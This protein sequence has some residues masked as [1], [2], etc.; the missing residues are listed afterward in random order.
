[1]DS[2]ET[3]DAIWNTIAAEERQREQ[4]KATLTPQVAQ[5]AGVLHN[6]YPFL[7]G[8]VKLSAA[9][10]GLTD[11]QVLGIA[12]SAARVKPQID[13]NKKSKKNWLQR[14]I[15][16]KLKTGSRYGFAALQL[17]TDLIQGAASQAF[18]DKPG[19]SG[20]FISTDLGSLIANDTEA[21]TGF[22]MGGRA[23]ELQAE[24]ARRFRGTIDGSAWTIGRGL[25]SVAFEPDSAAY[26]LMSGAFDAGIAIAT[27][28]VPGARQAGAAL[29]AAEEAGKGGKVVE[30]LAGATRIVGEGSREIGITRLTA[31][32]IDD[33]RKGIL[34]GNQV[35]Y[36][37]A[38]RFFG[39]ALGRRIVQRT[40]ETNDFA[41]TW[42]LW[43]RK[44]DA[45]T[46]QELAD[47]KTESEVM[48]VLLDKLGTQVVST[49]ELAGTKK[50]YLSL[51]QRNKML[52]AMP[53]GEGVSRAFSKLPQRSFNLS[54]AETAAD[55]V[56][57][58]NTIE[59]TMALFKV[60]PTVRAGYLNRAGR[61]LIDR[62]PSEV[63][64]FYDDFEVLLKDSMIA[65]GTN[66]NIVEQIYSNFKEYRQD[67]PVFSSDGLGS[68]DDLEIAQRLFADK[69]NAADLV[70]IG[71]LAAS[72]IAK[73]EF[74]IPDIRQVRRLTNNW[75][76][77]W[78]KK[79]PN[80]AKLAE[81][82]ELRLPFAVVE[83]FQEKIWRPVITLTVGNFVR[84]VVD[85]QVSIALSGKKGGVSPFVHP[86]QYLGLVRNRR[87]M[88][89]IMAQGFDEPV[90][91]RMVEDALVAHRKAVYDLMSSQYQ[92]PVAMHRKAVRMGVFMPYQRI[93]GQISADVARA[94]GDEL[95]RIS[96]DWAT[97]MYA[98]GRG[99]DEIIDIIRNGKESRFLANLDEAGR[100]SMADQAQ[101]WYRDINT[102]Y[103]NG[104]PI[105]N[106]A[107]NTVE[108]M[109]VNLDDA[110]NLKIV[111]E[112]AS[113]RL[114][115][116]T[117][118]DPR[119]KD[120]VGSGKMPT[121]V[122]KA[123]DIVGEVSDGARVKV[124][125]FNKATKTYD[126]YEATV[127]AYGGR[128]PEVE[129]QPFAWSGTGDTS[130][131]FEKFLQAEDIYNNPNMPVR[132]V[133]EVRNPNTPQ[134]A[135]LKR[136][137][138]R[139]IRKF[140]ASLYEQPVGTLERSP[141]FKNLYYQWVDK[142]AVSMDETS[143]NNIIDE[144]VAKAGPENPERYLPAGLWKKL[145]DL[146]DNPDKLYGTLSREE[147]NAF[148]SGHAID[149]MERMLYNA[150][151]RSNATDVLRLISPFAQQQLEFFGRLGRMGFSP[152]AGGRLGALPNPESFRKMQLVVEG[153]RDADPD[154][155]GKGFFF[156]DPTTGQWSFTFPLTGELTKLITGVRADLTLPIKGV[157]LGLDVRPGLGPFATIAASKIL[158][159][160]P[161]F[162]FMRNI[163]LPYGEKT[164]VVRSLVPSYVQKI[165]DG[166]SGRE[167]GRFFANTY[168]ETMQALSAT[169]K[170]DLSNPDEQE[171]MMNDARRKAQILV[172]LRGITQFTGP[173]SGDFDTTVPTD[174][175][176][177]HATGLAYA[178]Q[179]LRNDNYD[180]ATLRFIEIFGEDAF[181]YLSNKTIS[182]VGGLEASEEF[183]KWERNNPSLFKQFKDVAGYFGPT[184]T[185]F[186][187]EAYTRQLQ[188]GARR[189]LTPQEVL[190]AS[191]R[192]IGLAYYKDMRAKFGDSL[193]ENERQYLSDYRALIEQ[194]YPGFANMKFDPNEVSNK[195]DLL[196]QASAQE[197][198][199]GNQ[200]AEGLRF[201]QR[202]RELALAEAQ[203]RGFKSLG[204]TKLA[205]LHAYLNSYAESIIAKYPDFARVYNRVLSQEFE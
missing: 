101:A 133:G 141:I 38:N 17:P 72:E 80:I 70:N 190:D 94:H 143:I 61:I 202:V 2:P 14:N 46:T 16:D 173:A 146:K 33:I 85:S 165:A 23:R 87:L 153:G 74:H 22:F 18:D 8:G 198:L 121:V 98:T 83:S 73:R 145:N 71:P 76:W 183:S 48:N 102:R 103:K 120:I 69:D 108:W 15:V 140:H 175:G 52:K 27:P 124:R 113:R 89:D 193:K 167:G 171:R 55:Q 81:A 44:L 109:P 126:E 45:K 199:N 86:F 78:V 42:A 106:K 104:Q 96:A 60:D 129:V 21:G 50:T 192:A 64:K 139:M 191:Q 147:V 13:E 66:K 128:G 91:A 24:R 179:N 182:N 162:D 39:T 88:S 40:A 67:M 26:R 43:G 68:A 116:L 170:Y 131:N 149:Q 163:L 25:A 95:G 31:D 1:M 138:D 118:G 201:Y 203:N 125:S 177:I 134:A 135:T 169:G 204:S 151:E 157:A 11:E 56:G 49:R 185:E 4:L 29:R 123:D 158:P 186:D 111:L 112:G 154:G 127:V 41:E 159:D 148:A 197:D 114:D 20:F 156:K 194:K 35:D 180:T 195:I 110:D 62:N 136:S 36:Q 51:A 166:L 58:L 84:N 200:V 79:D 144:I 152:V 54:Q 115:K 93:S 105:L 150:A 53:L 196:F 57:A 99:T 160:T 189:R 130:R 19:V 32:E 107:A 63:E 117:G 47:A 174:Q 164:D 122:V 65:S 181:L 90:A 10:A 168:V 176:D 9:K 132:V 3:E 184:G 155:D 6:L 30:T 59:R 77:V 12:K 161:R 172:V 28:A 119:L 137:M 178:L 7:D 205:D 100:S 92:D 37:S 5:R 34:V 75:N 142:L 82:G 97:R 188:T 187:F